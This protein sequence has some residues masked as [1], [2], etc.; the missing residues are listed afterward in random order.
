MCL[1]VPKSTY[2]RLRMYNIM[3]KVRII[4]L[5]YFGFVKNKGERV[6]KV[7]EQGR[8]R[9]GGNLWCNKRAILF[10]FSIN[11][12][13]TLCRFAFY[14]SPIA[15]IVT[16]LVGY[17]TLWQGGDEGSEQKWRRQSRK[18]WRGGSLWWTFFSFGSRG[19]CRLFFV[20]G[21][22]FVSRCVD[23]V[24]ELNIVF[25]GGVFCRSH[26][27]AP[28]FGPQ[29]VVDFGGFVFSPVSREFSNRFSRIVEAVATSP[30]MTVKCK[31]WTHRCCSG[32]VSCFRCGCLEFWR[33]LAVAGWK[34]R[35]N[36]SVSA[37]S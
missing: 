8:A 19:F 36:A 25:G 16:I 27:N 33:N 17:G 30:R 6:G 2:G 20:F 37:D 29:F 4:F 12:Q 23:R 28:F 32:C 26:F 3:R 14:P 34:C 21:E 7:G 22:K 10:F 13:C 11:K 9:E 35:E 24:G 5:F 18:S 1:Y 15:Y 31:I